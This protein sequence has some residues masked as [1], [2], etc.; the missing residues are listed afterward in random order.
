MIM[1]L[2]NLNAFK[3]LYK[4]NTFLFIRKNNLKAVSLFCSNNNKLWGQVRQYSFTQKL[5]YTISG[6]I[7]MGSLLVTLAKVSND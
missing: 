4:E 1:D 3:S 6:A 2:Y 7:K 5:I